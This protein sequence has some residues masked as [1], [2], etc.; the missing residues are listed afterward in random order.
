VF[1]DCYQP[2]VLKIHQNLANPDQRRTALAE[3]ARTA[4]STRRVQHQ[5]FWKFY[6]SANSDSESALKEIDRSDSLNNEF[7]A[8]IIHPENRSEF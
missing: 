5:E 6:N 7:E 2:F 8:T 1:R 3:I 4:G